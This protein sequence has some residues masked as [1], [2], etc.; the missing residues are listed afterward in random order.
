MRSDTST[1]GNWVSLYGGQGY[2]I[3]GET[4]N[5]PSFASVVTSG[6]SHCTWAASTTD[7][8]APL[9]SS[10][11]GA[12]RV[13]ACWYSDSGFTVDVNLT[14]G[15][16]H[17]LALYALDWDTNGREERVDAVDPAT[18][19]VLDSR[20]VSSFTGGQY[21][22]YNVT[23]HV[24]FRITNNV[25]GTNAVLS[26]L[27]F[28]GTPPPP[29]P[30]P[31][32]TPT[33]TLRPT[34]TPTSTPTPV[35]TVTPTPTANPASSV[36]FVRSDTS[37]QGNWV[38]LYGGQGYGVLGGTSNLPSF[39]SVVTSGQSNYTW[40]SS[41]T[42]AP[43]AAYVVCSRHRRV[44][45]CWYSF[46]NF[47]V[48]VN[49]TDGITH[50]LALYALDWDTNGRTEQVDALDPTG[51][52]LDSRTVSSF[53]NGQ[54]LVYNV[55]GHVQFRIANLAGAN[56]V[57]SGFFFGDPPPPPT[58]TATPMATPRP[59]ATPV[60]HD[61]NLNKALPTQANFQYQGRF[62]LPGSYNTGPN[63]YC[64]QG[65]TGCS[66]AWSAGGLAFRFVNGAL[67]FFTTGHVYDGGQVYEFS[68]PKLD[69]SARSFTTGVIYTT[70][71]TQ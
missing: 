34:A 45:A 25:A 30:T 68:Y 1:Q 49:L 61:T 67:H 21:L 15:I 39:A 18:G 5:L 31:T 26:G 60:S 17:Q 3:A 53:A 20:T 8:R 12:G 36:T 56:A 59:T 55:T 58:P 38:S 65:Q 41:T 23:G 10:A 27:F 24:Q 7:P 51:S 57:L 33:A 4:T 50:Q 46:S 70:T 13:A 9:T 69:T 6:Q 37:T 28:G 14:D 22:V 66:T 71:L 2:S 43:C 44:A 19:A 62:Y 40:A 54:Y 16:T 29:T 42:D 11:A 35:S 32:V 48:D 47:T 52:V 64:T 63:D